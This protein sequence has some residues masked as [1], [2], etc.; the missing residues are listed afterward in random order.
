MFKEIAE[1]NQVVL[2]NGGKSKFWKM[3]Y[4]RGKRVKVIFKDQKEQFMH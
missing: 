2:K 4:L 3:L 1:N